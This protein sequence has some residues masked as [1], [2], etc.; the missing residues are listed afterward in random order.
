MTSAPPGG[1]EHPGGIGG[2]GRARRVSFVDALLPDGAVERAYDTGVRERRVRASR[3]SSSG[4]TVR[5]RRAAT[6]TWAR[7]ASGARLPVA[8]SRRGDRSATG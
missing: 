3:A 4:A 1:S 8:A 7:G 5:G 6:S 2:A